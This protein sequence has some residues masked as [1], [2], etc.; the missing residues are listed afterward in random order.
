MPMPRKQRLL[1]RKR[2]TQAHR[3]GIA[4]TAASRLRKT[5]KSSACA[6]CCRRRVLNAAPAEFNFVGMTVFSSTFGG[7]Q[8]AVILE[9]EVVV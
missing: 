2:R 9:A 6:M 3:G 7:R 4:S 8:A 1:K 5:S